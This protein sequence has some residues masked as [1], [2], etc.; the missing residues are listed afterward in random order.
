MQLLNWIHRVIILLAKVKGDDR[1][2]VLILG[3]VCRPRHLN[4]ICRPASSSSYPPG[5]TCIVGRVSIGLVWYLLCTAAVYGALGCGRCG[6]DGVGSTK[7]DR[8]FVRKRGFSLSFSPIVP[9]PLIFASF[10]SCGLHLLPVLL[11]LRCFTF[12]RSVP[13]RL[14][15]SPPFSPKKNEFVL[16]PVNC[17][18]Q[19]PRLV[20]ATSRPQKLSNGRSDDRDGF[21]VSALLF[22]SLEEQR[23]PPSNSHCTRRVCSTPPNDESLG[24]LRLSHP[25]IAFAIHHFPWHSIGRKLH[26]VALH[27]PRRTF[28]DVN[29]PGLPYLES[30]DRTPTTF[31]GEFDR[32]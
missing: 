7:Q 3:P 20:N 1:L 12:S 30:H 18:A 13:T 8:S 2:R 19:G 21:L 17:F 25:S 4:L 5:E 22:A 29:P 9:L 31:C 26:C 11:L 28:L 15:A 24:F 27:C 14:L 32:L 6:W 23:S 16:H 10:V